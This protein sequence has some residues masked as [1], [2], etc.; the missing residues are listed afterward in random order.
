MDLILSS[1]DDY[2]AMMHG[3]NKNCPR[4]R[5][6]HKSNTDS[7]RIHQNLCPQLCSSSIRGGRVSK[8]VLTRLRSDNTTRR[9]GFFF[10]LPHFNFGF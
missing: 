4:S 9:N 7:P 8:A 2:H 5:V 10:C 1:W 3:H 6:G